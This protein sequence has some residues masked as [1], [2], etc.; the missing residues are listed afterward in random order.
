MDVQHRHPQLR[1]HHDLCTSL[2]RAPDDATTNACT[3]AHP[4]SCT[5]QLPIE[6]TDGSG[7]NSPDKSPDAYTNS[8]THDAA[9]S[10]AN[11]THS[12][13]DEWRQTQL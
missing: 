4:N 7:A 3:H 10:A 9:D 5:H 6:R 2:R 1:V 8:Y 12:F 13:A 11:C